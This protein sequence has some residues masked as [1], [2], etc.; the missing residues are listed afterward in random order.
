MSDFPISSRLTVTI[1]ILQNLHNFGS[2]P[3]FES[4][5][6]SPGRYCNNGQ[7]LISGKW[8]RQLK[9]AKKAYSWSLGRHM[10]DKKNELLALTITVSSKIIEIIWTAAC[11]KSK[12]SSFSKFSLLW[13][14]DFY[15]EL[16][17]FLSNPNLF[18]LTLF[19]AYSIFHSFQE[20]CKLTPLIDFKLVKL[21]KSFFLNS[22]VLQNINQ[23]IHDQYFIHTDIGWLNGR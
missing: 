21:I 17:C 3:L 1:T 12:F 9:S 2:Q 8:G 6:Y 5:H 4:L 13:Q 18:L 22:S 16:W 7:R 10:T 14:T 11:L 23:F 20:N 15:L 19:L